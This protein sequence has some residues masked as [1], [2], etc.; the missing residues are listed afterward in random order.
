MLAVELQVR[1]SE[2]V[3]GRNVVRKVTVQRILG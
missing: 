2:I 1:V 3:L